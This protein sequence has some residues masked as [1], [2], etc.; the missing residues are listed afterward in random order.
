MTRDEFDDTYEQLQQA[1][2][3]H[4]EIGNDPEQWDQLTASRAELDA[5]RNA[6]TSARRSIVRR[7]DYAT[8]DHV[9]PGLGIEGGMSR[10]TRLM[11][12]LGAIVFLGSVASVAWLAVRTVDRPVFIDGPVTELLVTDPGCSW[13][14]A[15]PVTNS[16]NDVIR[17]EPS[18]LIVNQGTYRLVTEQ[19]TIGPNT[20]LVVQATV[21]L[22]PWPPCPA[23]IDEIDH[24]SMLLN[25]SS[26]NGAVQTTKHRF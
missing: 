22:E 18:N 8:P 20:T 14:L 16:T 24:G 10:R 26:S 6:N 12:G 5:A 4:A 7:R 15:V 13:L 25:W 3:R 1:S 17:I 11:A 2:N 21:N 23:T 19:S 9:Q